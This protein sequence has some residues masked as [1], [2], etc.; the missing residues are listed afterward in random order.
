MIFASPGPVHVKY[1]WLQNPLPVRTK[2][3]GGITSV[4][5]QHIL[6]TVLETANFACCISVAMIG[7]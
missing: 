3:Q 6:T 4:S 7:K 1:E 2:Y 5:P